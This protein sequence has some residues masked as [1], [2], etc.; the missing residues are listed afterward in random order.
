MD[1]ACQEWVKG[2]T[3]CLL[4]RLFRRLFDHVTHDVK[5]A[6]KY[7]PLAQERHYRFN[8]S[9]STKDELGTAFTVKRWLPGME[10]DPI[11][12][13]LPC[14]TVDFRQNHSSLRVD[15]DETDVHFLVMPF[16]NPETGI[17][18]LRIN[19]EKSPFAIWQVS[20]HALS[21]LFFPPNT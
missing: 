4:P 14:A 21:T 15:G 1:T 3:E 7:T 9:P 20:Q 10:I 17:C 8:I 5:A 2:Q 12:P 6:E 18:E 19:D 11:K 16:W 13:A